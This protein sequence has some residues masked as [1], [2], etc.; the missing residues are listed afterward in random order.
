VKKKQGRPEKAFLALR[1]VY[2]EICMSEWVFFHYQFKNEMRD[3]L[4]LKFSGI[5][6]KFFGEKGGHNFGSKN[7]KLPA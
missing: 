6:S 5:L 1:P 2:V 4:F 3:V 7:Q